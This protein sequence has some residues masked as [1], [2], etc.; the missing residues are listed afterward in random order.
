[1]GA[2][3]SVI[4]PAIIIT[5]DWRGLGRKMPAPNRSRSKRD[6]PVA[7]ISMAQQAKPKVIGHSDDFR[8]QR[9]SCSTVV[10]A[11]FGFA[12]LASRTSGD[13]TTRKSL[14]I[15]APQD[16]HLMPSA[17]TKYAL[18]S[19]AASLHGKDGISHLCHSRPSKTINYNTF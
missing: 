10:T 1:M 19:G 14:A 6:A 18:F 3:F 17:E 16:L 13:P 12:S 7:I 4:V 9:K 8:A 15:S 11:K 2:I 5:S